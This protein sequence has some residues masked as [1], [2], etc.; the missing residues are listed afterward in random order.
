MLRLAVGRKR[1]RYGVDPRCLGEI[2]VAAHPRTA[3]ARHDVKVRARRMGPCVLDVRRQGEEAAPCKRCGFHLQAVPRERACD[4][5]IECRGRRTQHAT[6]LLM[7]RGMPVEFC[8]FAQPTV[9]NQHG[10]T[11]CLLRLLERRTSRLSR[12]YY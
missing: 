7:L 10:C 9:H 1:P 5:G 4:T 2:P 12:R 3:A 11:V 6:L 8:T